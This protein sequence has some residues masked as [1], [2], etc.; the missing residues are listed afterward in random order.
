MRSCRLRHGFLFLPSFFFFFPPSL[1]ADFD[2]RALGDCSFSFSSGPWPDKNRSAA[3]YFPAT[4]PTP[5]L[6]PLSFPSVTAPQ[7]SAPG[8]PIFLGRPK[9]VIGI[10][11][12]PKNPSPFF[13]LPLPLRRV[14]LEEDSNRFPSWVLSAPRRVTLGLADSLLP[15]FPFPPPPLFPPSPTAR[16]RL[17]SPETRVFPDSANRYERR[18]TLI[19][20]CG[21]CSPPLFSLLLFFFSPGIGM[22]PRGKHPHSSPCYQR[23]HHR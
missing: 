16:L 8:G 2:S 18:P 3:D 1:A 11:L 12:P 6:F 22:R 5:L 21:C 4:P 10:Y 19:Q 7:D 13:P 17:D 20:L 9:R 23:R 15:L 14:V